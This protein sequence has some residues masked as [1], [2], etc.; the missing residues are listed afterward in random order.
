MQ[1]TENMS[2]VL[3]LL[4]NIP[5]FMGS[6]Q[7]MSMKKKGRSSMNREIITISINRIKLKCCK[8]PS[9]SYSLFF[10]SIQFLLW[11]ESI[12][13]TDSYDERV[14]YACR[15]LRRPSKYKETGYLECDSFE[16][17]T[18]SSI[19]CLYKRKK[20]K[21]TRIKTYKRK[22]KRHEFIS[23]K[24]LNRPLLGAY[25]FVII[26]ALVLVCLSVIFAAAREKVFK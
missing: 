23:S 16:R 11:F 5:R 6:Q 26:G 13:A 9:S 7:L 8:N 15:K 22:E 24:Q 21:K 14:K 25:E 3:V 1:H 19:T 18:R 4:A 17:A 12:I 20:R 10:E 2:P